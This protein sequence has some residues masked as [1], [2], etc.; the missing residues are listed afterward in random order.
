[1]SN[2]VKSPNLKTVEN[3]KNNGNKKAAGGM[4]QSNKLSQQRKAVS[5]FNKGGIARGCGAVAENKRKK[6]KYS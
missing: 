1:M 5:K 4:I 2:K 3:N 6:T